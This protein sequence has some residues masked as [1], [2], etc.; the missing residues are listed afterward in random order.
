MKAPNQAD[1]YEA[2]HA[3]LV[4]DYVATVIVRRR[5]LADGTL[6]PLPELPRQVAADRS[7]TETAL[8]L[9]QGLQN[10]LNTYEKSPEAHKQRVFQMWKATQ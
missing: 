4:L 10:V 3:R 5:M 1:C 2:R 8:K 6:K 9:G 7:Y